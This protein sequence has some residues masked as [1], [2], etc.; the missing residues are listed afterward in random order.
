MCRS[1]CAEQAG[2]PE[3]DPRMQT[4]LPAKHV[5]YNHACAYNCRQ[6][7]TH[8]TA[9][10]KT[11]SPSTAPALNSAT[12]ATCKDTAHLTLPQ[13]HGHQSAVSCLSVCLSQHFETQVGPLHF[14]CTEGV[15]KRPYDSRT[16]CHAWHSKP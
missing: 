5:G 8:T 16:W 15:S 2:M 3:D 1:L 4:S 12:H 9:G 7:R 14:S 11:D 6:E 13:T 10:K